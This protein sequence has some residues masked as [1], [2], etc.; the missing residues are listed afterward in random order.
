[1][2]APPP[3][4][5]LDES[6]NFVIYASL[7][8]IK[9]VN[10]TTNRVARLLGKVE[11]TERFLRIALYQVLRLSSVLIWARKQTSLM[12]SFQFTLPGLSAVCVQGRRR[13]ACGSQVPNGPCIILSRRRARTGAAACRRAAAARACVI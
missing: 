1:M 5:I 11:N 10:L 3:N 8:G 2:Q 13:A 4:A 12:C 7:L 9:V 6:G